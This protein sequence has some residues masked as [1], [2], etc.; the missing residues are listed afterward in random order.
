MNRQGEKVIFF[1]LYK[2]NPTV[3]ELDTSF[4]RKILELFIYYMH[5]LTILFAPVPDKKSYFLA[6]I[7]LKNSLNVRFWK[8]KKIIE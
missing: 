6:D 8:K 5:K 3:V 2:E 7:N 1:I 4:D